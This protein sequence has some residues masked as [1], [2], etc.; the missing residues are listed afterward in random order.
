MSTLNNV[1]M[2][3]PS[4]VAVPAKPIAA[5]SPASAFDAWLA[6][7]IGYQVPGYGEEGGE[8]DNPSDPGGFTWRGVTLTTFRGWRDDPNATATD[9]LA[10][11]EDELVALY[12]ALYWN[13]V[14]G[15]ALPG[16]LALEVADF[17]VNAGPRQ[18]AIILQR[19]VGVT[20][21]GSIGP[22]TLGAVAA[23][24]LT[25]L[26]GRFSALRLGFYQSLSTFAT[27]GAGWTGRNTRCEAAAMALLP[28]VAPT[29]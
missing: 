2:A 29:T 16:A 27:F 19:A 25:T 11:S 14:Q 10:I 12:G 22:Q 6:F 21:D 23:A 17:G 7:T 18:S 24:N 20:Q 26:V 28:N 5:P 8:A 1:R 9:L 3:V 13:T 15:D 4:V